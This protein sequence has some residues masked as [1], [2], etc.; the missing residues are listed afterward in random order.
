MA[1]VPQLLILVKGLP[2]AYNRDLQEDKPAIFDALDTVTACLELMPAIISGATL[3]REIIAARIEEGF[4]DATTLMEY[5]ILRGVPMRTGH[6]TVGKLVALAES[7]GCRLADL[8][9]ADLQAASELIDDSV[10]S[11]LG[12]QN[13][14]NAFKSYGSGGREPVARQLA[15]WRERLGMP[16]S[17]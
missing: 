10:G 14:V 16:A 15:A 4:L 11:V 12:T 1:A 5:L 13:A 7:R 9:L 6:E 8:P 2:L 17:T 3:N